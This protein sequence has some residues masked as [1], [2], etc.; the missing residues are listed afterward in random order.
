MATA[1]PRLYCKETGGERSFEVGYQEGS[2]ASSAGANVSET[3]L[4]GAGAGGGGGETGAE[5]VQPQQQEQGVK[6]GAATAYENVVAG[7]GKVEKRACAEGCSSK[8]TCNEELGRCDCPGLWTGASCSEKAMPSCWLSDDYLTACHEPASCACFQDCEKFGIIHWTI[9]YGADKSTYGNHTAFYTSQQMRIETDWKGGITSQVPT[10]DGFTDWEYRALPPALCPKS[11]NNRGW[12]KE[13]LSCACR[14][15]FSGRS[16]ELPSDKCL[17]DCSGRGV[18]EEGLFCHCEGGAYGIDCSLSLS[19]DSV[20]QVWVGKGVRGPKRVKG[21]RPRI[22][23]YELPPHLNAW[24]GMHVLPQDR[25]EPLIFLER[26]LHSKHRTTNPAK[27]DFFFVPAWIRWH[28]LRQQYVERVVAYIRE[29]WPFW[30]ALHGRRHIWITPDDWGACEELRERNPAFA[31]STVL[32]TWGYK[33]NAQQGE[34]NPCFMDGQDVAIPSFVSSHALPSSPFVN[35]VRAGGQTAPPRNT[36]FYFSG[37]PGQTGGDNERYSFGARQQLFSLFKDRKDLGFVV[38]EGPE[39][40][41]EEDMKKAVFCFAPCGSGFS[42]RA[43]MSVLLGCIP[44]VVQENVVQPYDGELL[45]W[46]DLGLVLSNADLPRLPE[47][48]AGVSEEER[49]KKVEAMR[50]LWP[51]FV[52]TAPSQPSLADLGVLNGEKWDARLPAV[53]VFSSVMELLGKRVLQA[54]LQ[55]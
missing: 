35:P 15:G 23:V 39:Y 22:F 42:P 25:P 21:E 36:L 46:K 45:D 13:D 27:A 40:G 1:K 33:R 19:A 12:C 20:P 55:Q 8:G 53:D 11:C 3:E 54:I 52:W 24:L 38:K 2:F 16:C 43:I 51:R 4:A 9:C 18:C 50:T 49:A 44:V 26:L 14:P 32:T 34:A 31:N 37:Y 10:K 41:F 30:D 7:D 5:Q 48:L 29:Q 6:K 28:S 47:I 17:N